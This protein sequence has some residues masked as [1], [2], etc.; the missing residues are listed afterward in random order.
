MLNLRPL[1]DRVIV[2]VID[3]QETTVS[4]IVLPA[5]AQGEQDRGII[6]AI[7]NGRWEQGERVP[8]DLAVGQVVI[9]SKFA[10][11]KIEYE[12]SDYLVLREQDIYAAEVESNG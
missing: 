2:E 8:L 1:G 3:P 11:G 12:D 7:G 10:G 4:G 9:F 5:T 6:V